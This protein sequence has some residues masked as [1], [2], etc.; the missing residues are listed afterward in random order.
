[1][2]GPMIDALAFLI[3][4]ASPADSDA[5]TALL[6]ASY[7]RLLAASYDSDLLGRTLSHMTR[8]NPTLLTSGTYYV[9]ERE[10]G[11]LVGC[12]GWTP[13]RPG[14]GEIIEGE[15]HIRHFATHPEWVRRGVGT[16]LL[17][18]CFCD[19]RSLGV[20]KLYCFSTLNAEPFYRASGFGA[21]RP[22]DVPMGPCLTFP[23]VLMSCKVA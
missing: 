5:V 17:A 14:S 10:P 22:I 23:G 3:R 1:V 20:R 6:V 7:S 19:A 13:V 4:A 21:V 12:G 2:I 16:S 9:A 18:R 8:A 11:N 15:A